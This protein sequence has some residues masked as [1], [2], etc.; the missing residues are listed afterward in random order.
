MPIL[1]NPGLSNGDVDI[2]Q[3]IDYAH[4]NPVDTGWVGEP[5]QYVIVV[6]GTMVAVKV[7]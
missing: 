3:K 6:Q 5:D 7:W 4:N 2:L 1:H